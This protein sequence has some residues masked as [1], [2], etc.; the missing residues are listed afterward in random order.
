V[1]DSHVLDIVT[2]PEGLYFGEQDRRL[3]RIV[4]LP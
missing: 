4:P 2:T 1:Q 3:D